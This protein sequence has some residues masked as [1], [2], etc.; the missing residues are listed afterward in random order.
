MF[1][2]GNYLTDFDAYG[3]Q[4]FALSLSGEFNFGSEWNSVSLTLYAA[5]TQLY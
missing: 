1:N 5:Q 2:I 4:G 3:V